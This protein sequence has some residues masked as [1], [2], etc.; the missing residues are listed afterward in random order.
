ML[1]FDCFN[2][3]N[4]V[5]HMIDNLLWTSYDA[6][7]NIHLILRPF[8]KHVESSQK[9]ISCDSSDDPSSTNSPHVL[10][11]SNKLSPN[12]YHTNQSS[13]IFND[14]SNN[15]SSLQH[16]ANISSNMNNPLDEPLIVHPGIILF[17]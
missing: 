1:D 5:A 7:I 4:R 13:F 14:S 11:T 15:K 8:N 9:L 2:L 10:T 17:H 3:L 16:S 6:N 12:S